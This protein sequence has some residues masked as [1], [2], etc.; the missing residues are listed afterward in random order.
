DDVRLNDDHPN[1]AG[2]LHVLAHDRLMER[3]SLR[4]LSLEETTML[5]AELMGQDEA[6]E[7]FVS[8]VYRRSKG[9]PRLIEAM[10]WSLGGRLELQGE[11]GSGS[12]GRVFRAF[13]RRTDQNVAA[14]LVLAREGIDLS[15]LLRFQ[16][17]GAVL[18]SLD[19]P[20]I[21]EVYDTF[22]E[23][24]AACIIMELL[25]GQSLAKI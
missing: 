10:V 4:L 5:V 11:I 17:E 6:S 3:V 13:D 15:D 18:A 19:L 2:V 8:F 24:H 20:N 16:R 21:V 12:T 1:F 7:E 25:D 22:A 23:E 9:L 14:K